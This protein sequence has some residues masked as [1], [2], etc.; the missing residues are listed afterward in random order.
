MNSIEKIVDLF[1]AVIIIF[2]FP[3]LYFGQKQDSITQTLVSN[4]TEAFVNDIRS[5][6]YLTKEMYDN[7]LEELS[8]TGLIYTIAA[9]HRQLVYEPEYR[10]RTPEE[11]AKDQDSAYTGTNY[12]TYHPIH[13]DIPVVSDPVSG[14]LNTETNESVLASAVNSPASS[15]HI[16]VDTCY[17]GTKHIHSGSSSSG[18]GCYGTLNSGTSCSFSVSKYSSSSYNINFPCSSCKNGTC[19]GLSVSDWYSCP[20]GHSRSTTVHFAWSCSSC[21]SA[22]YRNSDSAPSTC[23]VTTYGYLMNCGKTAN[24]YYN[25]NTE[26]FS[27]CNQIV[28]SIVPTH[29]I[30]TVATGDPLITTVTANFIDNST[31]VVIAETAF[32]TLNITQ[33]Q[34]VTL[35]YTY[36]LDGVSYSKTCTIKVT[37][38]P[39]SK[40][41]DNG[42][43]YNLNTNGSDPGCPYCREWLSSLVI[44]FPAIGTITIYKGTTLQ[45]NGIT[46][47]ATYMD[48]RTESLQTEFIDNLDTQYVGSQEVT[49]SYKGKYITLNVITKRNLRLC[50]ICNKQYELYSDES[51][52]GCPFCLSLTPI[53]NNKVMEYYNKTFTDEILKELYEGS[54]I[55]YFT[56]RDYILFNIKSCSVSWAT[57]LR[58]TFNKNIGYSGIQIICGGNIR[59]EGRE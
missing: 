40:T 32:S 11:V 33:N 49:I 47:L 9:E 27:V 44:T 2:L 1:V 54:G 53:F 57:R 29:P 22:Y 31:T 42:H 39:R 37:V 56:D 51:D 14:N 19:T 15:T 5:N 6:G 46:L 18:G 41:C 30:Q 7:Y 10:F 21:G 24:H 16:H 52:P 13:T 35:T 48:G 23:G 25:G 8:K 28:D 3:L 58:A 12:Y 50:T 59:E 4:Q 26:V 38:I 34:T 43:V 17:H 55:Y 36:I 45:D 20:A